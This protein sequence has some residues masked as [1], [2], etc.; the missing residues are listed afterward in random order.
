MNHPSFETKVRYATSQVTDEELFDIDT[1]LAG[2]E[3]CSDQIAGIMYLRDN[4][5]TIWDFFTL[6][7]YAELERQVSYISVLRKAAEKNPA[8]QAQ[9]RTLYAKIKAGLTLSVK[10]LLDSSKQLSLIAAEVKKEFL[11][12]A[13]F[14]LEP[15][16]AGV[17]D[18]QQVEA[19]QKLDQ[20]RDFLKS[21]SVDP[22]VVLLNEVKAIAPELVESS[23]LMIKS[24][25][26][27]EV[28]AVAI[29]SHTKT[30][31]VRFW[32]Y[33]PQNPPTVAILTSLSGTERVENLIADE[34]DH[35][36]AR[37]EE[38]TEGISGIKI[39]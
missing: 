11:P 2:C 4:F 10:V 1:H 17:G 33:D 36:I 28:G 5:E 37:F 26:G 23:Q 39:V 31:E 25:A 9:I 24:S 38:M 34:N 22:A 3:A 15:R 19:A 27:E 8:I 14:Y 7:G 16:Y 13:G 21:N 30:M 29:D 32:K 18:R 35:L 20:S 6:A 12:E